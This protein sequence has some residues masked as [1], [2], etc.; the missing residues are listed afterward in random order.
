MV[1]LIKNIFHYI[2]A[3]LATLYYG[4]P[5][6]SMTV[7]G[8]TGTDGKTTTC[9]LLFHILKTAKKNVSLISSVEA[10]IG[11]S[12]IDTGFHVTT[13]SPWSLQK[14]FKKAKDSGCEIVVLEVSSHGLDQNRVVGAS[15]DI[16]IVTNVSH[17]HI[18]YHRNFGNY[19]LAKSKLLHGTKISIL[20]SDDSNFDVLKS[21]TSGKVVTYSI[22]QK[23]NFTQSSYTL[24][25]K[26]IGEFNR[27]N[28]LAAAAAA[29]YCN[30]SKK[31]I[32]KAI[33]NFPGVL[34]RMEKVKISK[35]FTVIIDFAHKINALEKA[36]SA[37]RKTT[38]NKLIVVFGCAGLRD[39]VKRPIMGEIAARLAD[40][41]VLTAEDPR[42][43]DV[44]DIINE[45]SAGCH[46]EGIKELS[47][48]DVKRIDQ[49]MYKKYFFKIPDRQ[50]A[51][52]FAIRK[53]AK[54]GDTVILCGK[55]HEQSMCWGTH[56]YPWDERKALQK[57][58]YGT[59]KASKKV[60]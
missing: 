30:V 55:G 13:P 48:H 31:T 29:K 42:T 51:I 50:E 21:H 26:I 16:G 56:E 7:V 43:E 28:C 24:A 11:N 52:N 59:V 45:I 1:R 22:T 47:K 35:P 36:L 44:R 33:R 2:S 17:E 18:D 6:R 4:Y 58:L 20:N 3:V 54:A 39:R 10:R 40:V 34:G 8:V 14:L 15:I 46:K 38:R 19:L 53:L 57:A 25:P 5:A 37:A 12:H 9:H 23:A 41:V 27:Y 49:K 60:S 32:E